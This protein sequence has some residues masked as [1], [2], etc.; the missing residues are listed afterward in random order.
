MFEDTKLKIFLAV[1]NNGSFT[2]AAKECGITQPAVSRS[3]SALESETGMQLFSRERGDIRLT[4]KGRCFMEYAE[5]ILYW[6]DSARRMF[7]PEGKAADGGTIRISADP[8]IAAYLLPKAISTICASRPG[9]GFVIKDTGGKGGIAEPPA[10]ADVE[11]SVYPSPDTLDFQGESKLIGVMEAAAAASPVNRTL[12]SA[13]FAETKPFSTLAGIHVSNSFAV[14]SGYE[15][16]LSPD[17]RARVA[18]SSFSIETLK[19][20]ALA[21]GSIV[22][23]LPE[24]AAKKEFDNGELLKMPVQL[25]D[26]TYDVHFSPAPEF[27]GKS[28]CRI[29][30]ESIK[31]SF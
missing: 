29:L 8:V 1:A 21:S 18:V 3:I 14:W 13:P 28:I 7:G 19:S 24:I 12:A 20:V 10:D 26:F 17:V 30:A 23:I 6:Y 16:F 2:L 25:Q 27:A 11:I 9:T 5:R 15:S 22:A 31:F 4:A